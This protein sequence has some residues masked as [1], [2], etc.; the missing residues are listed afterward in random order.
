M[1]TPRTPAAQALATDLQKVKSQSA[2]NRVEDALCG[3]VAVAEARPEDTDL[4]HAVA[5]V[6]MTQTELQRA[7][8]PLLAET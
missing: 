5:K 1:V 8:K 4:H 6:L 3:L 2:I 7:L